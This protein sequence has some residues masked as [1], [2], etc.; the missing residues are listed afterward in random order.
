MSDTKK[1]ITDDRDFIWD[2]LYLADE[3]SEQG[4][5]EEAEELYKKIAG[6]Q[7][8]TGGDANAHYGY[9]LD[10]MGR[11]AEAFDWSQQT[12]A[13]FFRELPA[14]RCAPAWY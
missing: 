8:A 3:L 11:Y 9:L 1:M 2:T 13:Y 12:P 6:D 5:Y 14:F 4:K 7:D 10:K